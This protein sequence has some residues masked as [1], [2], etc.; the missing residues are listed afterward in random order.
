ML[1]NQ[2][3]FLRIFFRAKDDDVVKLY[4]LTSLCSVMSYEKGQNPSVT[5][6]LQC[7]FIALQLLI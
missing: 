4:D 5:Y 7:Y 6:Q 3:I 2:L 1:I